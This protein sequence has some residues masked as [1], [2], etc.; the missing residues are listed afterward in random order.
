MIFKL[1]ETNA[2]YAEFAIVKVIVIAVYVKVLVLVPHPIVSVFVSNTNPV[3]SVS[4]AKLF[5]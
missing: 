5:V 4:D 1:N 3:L 2:V